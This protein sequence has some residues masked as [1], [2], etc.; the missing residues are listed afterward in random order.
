LQAKTKSS[1]NVINNGS[2]TSQPISLQQKKLNF[3][4]R[5][6]ENNTCASLKKEFDRRHKM[7]QV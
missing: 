3:T 4:R 2:V 6:A 7:E 5:L 1:V